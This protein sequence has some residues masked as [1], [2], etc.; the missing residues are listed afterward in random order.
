[1]RVPGGPP[2]VVENFIVEASRL[3]HRSEVVSTFAFYNGADTV[4]R[5]HVERLGPTTFLTGLETVL[6]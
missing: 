6:A 1:M 4:L 2:I 3:G 5:E